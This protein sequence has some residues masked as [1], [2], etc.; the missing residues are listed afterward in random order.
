MRTSLNASISLS[1]LHA[2][3]AGTSHAV[4]DDNS[5]ANHILVMQGTHAPPSIRCVCN[6]SHHHCNLSSIFKHE[7]NISYDMRQFE[8][9]ERRWLALFNSSLGVDLRQA[10]KDDDEFDPCEDG[11]RSVCWKVFLL[12]GP[13]SKA[14][15]TKKV[16]DSRSAY[17]SLRD[18]F[19]KFI[20]NPDD[21]H[22]SADPL[23]DDESVSTGTMTRSAEAD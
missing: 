6:I 3:E 7:S 11:L 17:T 10:I 22:S 8:D 18:H 16:K 19:L 2:D 14:S 5:P 23:A 20:D 4:S 15:W 21:L 12:N 13:L 9:I 1:D